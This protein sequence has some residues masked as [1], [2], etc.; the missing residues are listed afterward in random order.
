MSQAISTD[1]VS[2]VRSFNRF[3]TDRIGAL[4]AGLLDSPYSLTEARIVFELAQQPSIEVVELRRRLDIDPGYLSRILGRF[5]A[6]GIVTRERSSDDGR[7]QVIRLTRQ[8]RRAFSVLDSRSAEQVARLLDPLAEVER[9]RLVAS[10]NAIRETLGERRRGGDVVLR[11][12]APG[13]YGWIVSRHGAIYADEYGWDEAF[14]ALVARIVGDHVER[15]DP[16]RERAWIAELDGQRA[17]CVVCV[18]KDLAT[19]QLRL[20]LVEPWARGLGIGSRLVDECIRFARR[21]RYERIALW[22]NDVLEDAR[23]IYERA[24]F[25]LIDEHAHHSFGQDLVGQH[26]GREL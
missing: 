11:S 23:R 24:G 10:M 25:E 15:R 17:G 13:D 7:R 5:A 18:R 2:A 22:T 1:D 4:R 20:L 26:W 12:P 9:R 21:A 19:A 8:G 14:E 6:G 16:R 3:Y